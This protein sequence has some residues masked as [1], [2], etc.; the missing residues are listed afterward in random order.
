M[1]GRIAKL[2]ER[3]SGNGA[4]AR[5]RPAASYSTA[6]AKA[7]AGQAAE[8][9]EKKSGQQD[10]QGLKKKGQDGDEGKDE[11]KKKTGTSRGKTGA[12]SYSSRRQSAVSFSD[13]HQVF[14]RKYLL[15]VIKMSHTQ[16][17]P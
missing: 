5:P 4:A 15:R 9:S 6:A 1:E 16:C 13:D 14:S 11:V 8:K 17:F 7:V 10:V 12:S 3:R 2:Q